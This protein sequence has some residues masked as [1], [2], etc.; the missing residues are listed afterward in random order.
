MP[1]KKTIAKHPSRAGNSMREIARTTA[2]ERRALQKDVA[3]TALT[4]TPLGPL[5]SYIGMATASGPI[6]YKWAIINPHALLWLLC[7]KNPAMR[8]MLHRYC[9][10]KDAGLVLYADGT[11]PGNKLAAWGTRELI[12]WYWTFAAFPSWVRAREHGWFV[13]GTMAATRQKTILGE[14]SGVAKHILQELFLCGTGVNFSRGYQL[15]PF[16]RIRASLS[17]FLLDGLAHKYITSTKGASG[18]ICCMLCRNIVNTARSAIDRRKQQKHYSVA[19][20]ADCILHTHDSFC[21]EVDRLASIRGHVT[22]AEFAKQEINIG[23]V[24]DEHAITH[25]PTL[26]D[27]YSVTKH[28]YFDAMHCLLTSGGV[29]QWEVNAFLVKAV[30]LP[31]SPKI[32][33]ALLDSWRA[34]IHRPKHHP[35]LIKDF[36]QKR[37]VMQADKHHLKSFAGECM[38]FLP[39]VVLLWQRMFQPDGLMLAEGRCLELLLYPS[40]RFGSMFHYV[41]TARCAAVWLATVAQR[42]RSPHYYRRCP[43]CTV[44]R[45]THVR[46]H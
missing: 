42:N 26:R 15:S 45:R 29:A 14:A 5:R 44:H 43:H 27:V 3:N 10:D 13:L 9:N 23:L 35:Y 37:V 30:K 20:R 19:T 31:H 8:V 18:K 36:A 6:D 39:Q 28:T 24:Y 21:A 4:M 38:S 22:K 32:T 11:T 34:A 41:S 2:T 40:L 7:E 25:A 16:L 12:C 33:L 46:R 17:C 1:V